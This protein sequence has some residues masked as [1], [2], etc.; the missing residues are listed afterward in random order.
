MVLM[1]LNN[2]Y[3]YF[4]QADFWGER[5]RFCVLSLD[6]RKKMLIAANEGKKLNV[7]I[8]KYKSSHKKIVQTLRL[9]QILRKIF[10][11]CLIMGT[12]NMIP[13]LLLCK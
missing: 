10:D 2:L 3:S 8:K 6:C 9:M 4:L 1:I 5:G 7:I 11:Y 12:E 13:L